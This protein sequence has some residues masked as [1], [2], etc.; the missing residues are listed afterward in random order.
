MSQQAFENLAV[1]VAPFTGAFANLQ[2]NGVQITAN[3]A[4]PEFQNGVSAKSPQRIRIP[5]D[6]TL[7]SAI[8]SQFPAAGVSPELDLSTSLTVGGVTVSG[9]SATMDFELI[10]AGD[11][12]F[13]DI[14][15]QQNNQPYLSQ[16]LRVFGA[17]PKNNTVPFPGGP[18]F[19]DDSV[20]GAYNYVQ[21]LLGYL[22]NSPGFTNL[23]GTD[24]FALLPD[25]QGEGQIGQLVAPFLH[26]CL[27]SC[28][29][30]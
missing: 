21:A 27:A 14:D 15:P 20:T 23:F 17:V 18:T 7:S 26:C 4:G 1:Q 30:S 2:G 8:M 29:F 9:S 12:Y 6:I 24:P 28:R 10:A 19:S 25:Q 16:D 5:F 22:N 13:T 3:P 11:P